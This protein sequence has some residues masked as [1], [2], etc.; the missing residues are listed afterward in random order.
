LPCYTE[1]TGG[2]SHCQMPAP[3]LL[4]GHPLDQQYYY[5]EIANTKLHTDQWQ[6]QHTY[7]NIK[8]NTPTK[9]NWT[10]GKKSGDWN[11]Q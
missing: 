7:T 3:N 4:G 8:P 10:K 6:K 2:L 5:C 1:K 9:Q 11:H